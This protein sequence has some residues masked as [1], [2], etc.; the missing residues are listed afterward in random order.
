MEE[1]SSL[2]KQ[3]NVN[4]YSGRKSLSKY[5]FTTKDKVRIDQISESESL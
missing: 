4:Q 5:N 2:P 3:E 1:N